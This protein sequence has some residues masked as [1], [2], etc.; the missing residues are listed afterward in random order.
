MFCWHVWS[1]ASSSPS[2]SDGL[3][4]IHAHFVQA[5]PSVWM[6]AQSFTH[7][8]VRARRQVGGIQSPCVHRC[9][10]DAHVR[11][12][13]AGDSVGG[14]R[15][16]WTCG[17]QT[18]QCVP[19]LT[20]PV[21][22]QCLGL[23]HRL[24]CAYLPL[25]RCAGGLTPLCDLSWWRQRVSTLSDWPDVKRKAGCISASSRRQPGVAS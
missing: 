20:L 19:S 16:V 8:C 2:G 15:G 1:L 21:K 9:Q 22:R 10:P 14:M 23:N 6:A 17:D 11:Q 7:A 12:F 5:T 24:V 25:P 13:Q 4:S 18:W 3:S